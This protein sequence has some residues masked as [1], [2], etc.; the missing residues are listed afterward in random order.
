MK[1][2]E[3][4]LSEKQVAGLLANLDRSEYKT[5][6]ESLLEKLNPSSELL[7]HST[8][9]VGDGPSAVNPDDLKPGVEREREG[10]Y[11]LRDDLGR[12]KATRGAPCDSS[13]LLHLSD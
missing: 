9:P 13:G 10:H 4:A 2:A 8:V 12:L 7:S 3:E 1:T 5:L 6:M 11:S